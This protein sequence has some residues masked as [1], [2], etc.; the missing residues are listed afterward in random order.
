MLVV[1]K[2]AVSTE[3]GCSV[4][5]WFRNTCREKKRTYGFQ[6]NQTSPSRFLLPQKLVIPALNRSAGTHF[7]H[8]QSRS[9]RM[10]QGVCDVG[11]KLSFDPPP[12]YTWLCYCN[13]CNSEVRRATRVLERRRAMSDPAMLICCCKFMVVPHVP[14]RLTAQVGSCV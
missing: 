1:F 10:N 4:R 3:N 2:T 13:S 12:N 6:I 14:T 9:W 8:W 5:K 7:S 11:L